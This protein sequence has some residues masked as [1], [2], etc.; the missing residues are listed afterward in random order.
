MSVANES[1]GRNGAEAGWVPQTV[2][3]TFGEVVWLMSQS[4]GH[5]EFRIADLEWLVMPA[6]L[7]RQFRMFRHEGKPVAVVPYAFVSGDIEK[8]I[9]GG[10]PSMLPGDWQSGDRAWIIQVI[11]PFGQAEAFAK[12]TCETVL[13]GREVK[14]QVVGTGPASTF[15]QARRPGSA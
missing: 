14:M 3:E 1:G 2:A 12:E 10:A 4:A 6:I 15:T 13:A 7:A 11:A 8:R 5:K 9:Q